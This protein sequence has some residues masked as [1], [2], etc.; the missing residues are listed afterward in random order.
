MGFDYC[1][2]LNSFIENV[3]IYYLPACSTSLAQPT[4]QAII[5]K[6]KDAWIRHW[7][8]KKTTLIQ[9]GEW[10]NDPQ[11][12]RGWFGKLKNPRKGFFL[13]LAA[14]AVRDVNQEQDFQGMNIAR[15]SM[16]RC[17]LSLDTDGV[18]RCE[19]LFQELQD[20]IAEF[21]NHFDGEQ[22]PQVLLPEEE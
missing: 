21:P 9:G 22:V 7:E 6:I 10:Q 20:I 16:I 17:G 14:E 5:Q 13:A 15:K 4:D 18:W 3:Q 1:Y 19:Q 11:G 12:R 8:T 2:V